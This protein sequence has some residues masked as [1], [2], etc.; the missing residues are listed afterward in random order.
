LSNPVKPAEGRFSLTG[1][2]V[3]REMA[4]EDDEDE[5]ESDSGR[6][7]GQIDNYF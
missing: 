2:S 7:R 4:D 1:D 3:I 5:N 6:L